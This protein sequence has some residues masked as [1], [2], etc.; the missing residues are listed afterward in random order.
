MWQEKSPG[1]G[2]IETKSMNN[3]FQDMET[4]QRVGRGRQVERTARSHI[5][6]GVKVTTT[7]QGSATARAKGKSIRY[8]VNNSGGAGNVKVYSTVAGS[9]QTREM[10]HSHEEQEGRVDDP[11]G[12]LVKARLQMSGDANGSLMGSPLGFL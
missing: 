12:G 6:A 5:G 4:H 9:T 3:N 1:P 11:A 8:S 2:R 10:P 7:R